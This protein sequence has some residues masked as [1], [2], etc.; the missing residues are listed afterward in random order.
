MNGIDR[1]IPNPYITFKS[2]ERRGKIG[3][4]LKMLGVKEMILGA[5]RKSFL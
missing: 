5:G 2:Q 4:S 1:R 3:F